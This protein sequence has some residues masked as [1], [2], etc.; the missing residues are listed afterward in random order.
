MADA[1]DVLEIERVAPE[2]TKDSFLG[3]SGQSQKRIVKPQLIRR[4]VGMSRELFS[5]ISKNVEVGGPVVPG[6]SDAGYTQTKVKLGLKKVRK[7][8]F[9]NFYHPGRPEKTGLCHWMRVGEEHLEY[10]FAKFCRR[11]EV[12]TFSEEEFDA[13]LSDLDDTWSYDETVHLFDLCN[14]FE[15]RFY[16]IYDRFDRQKY[17]GRSLEDLKKRYYTVINALHKARLVEHDDG[18]DVERV[19]DETKRKSEIRARKTP[20]PP[21]EERS[22]N[23][24]ASTSTP[25]AISAV[26][27]TSGESKNSEIK[28]ENEVR[29]VKMETGAGNEQQ[30]E[31]QDDEELEEDEMHENESGDEELPDLNGTEEVEH[32]LSRS[33]TPEEL[34]YK[35]YGVGFYFDNELERLRKIQLNRSLART[36]EEIE[37][38][39][40]LLSELKQLLARKREMKRKPLTKDMPEATIEKTVVKRKSASIPGTPSSVH[41]ETGASEIK[42]SKV[43]PQFVLCFPERTHC[44]S[45]LSRTK[46]P[47]DE[48]ADSRRMKTQLSQ[49]DQC[50]TDLGVPSLTVGSDDLCEKYNKLRMSIAALFNLK[51]S[52]EHARAELQSLCDR[53]HGMDPAGLQRLGIDPQLL[54]PLDEV[55][56][57][58][59]GSDGDVNRARTISEMLQLE[60]SIGTPTRKRK[61]ALEQG[62]VLK[63]LKSRV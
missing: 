57:E 58:L 19:G 3:Q 25:C 52:T 38:E 43:S 9:T 11:I 37:E 24:E 59:N 56:V 14:R 29:T 10:P 39:E 45:A 17:P 34:T 26:P 35:N 44:Y 23:A 32:G 13:C 41:S 12:P 46:A 15:M 55:N 51:Y 33:V 28:Q 60:G 2:L 36:E 4:P 20:D 42:D 22:E 48:S 54:T 31:E 47:V 62:N 16:V 53:F 40:D 30:G 63:K 27:G 18:H 6:D 21:I 1:L 49:I 61:A 50:L 5:L 8:V 7:W